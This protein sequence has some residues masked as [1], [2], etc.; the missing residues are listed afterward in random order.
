MQESQA[1]LFKNDFDASEKGFQQGIDMLPPAD[2]DVI[3]LRGE[4][5]F[6]P[7]FQ[8]KSGEFGQNLTEFG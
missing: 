3:D 5:S 1:L 2:K 8:G 7:R 4:F 6:F